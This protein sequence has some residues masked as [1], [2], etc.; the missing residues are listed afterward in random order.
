MSRYCETWQP[1]AQAAPL[2]DIDEDALAHTD[3]GINNEAAAAHV[4]IPDPQAFPKGLCPPGDGFDL[5]TKRQRRNI[6]RESMYDAVMR[7]LDAAKERQAPELFADYVEAV[8][9][10]L[11]CG[12]AI[13]QAVLLPCVYEEVLEDGSKIKVQNKESGVLAFSV[14]VNGYMRYMALFIVRLAGGQLEAH[15]LRKPSSSGPTKVL[16]WTMRVFFYVCSCRQPLRVE[17]TRAQS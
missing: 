16:P 11:H 7:V 4:P 8:R 14:P 3:H 15:Y 6:V 5:L 2:S 1:P 9:T 17:D 13:A 10:E 12:L